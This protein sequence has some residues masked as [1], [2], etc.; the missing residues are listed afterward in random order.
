MKLRKRY[1]YYG[2]T[3]TAQN[4]AGDL[5][6]NHM[7]PKG[8]LKVPFQSLFSLYHWFPFLRVILQTEILLSNYLLDYM[9]QAIIICLVENLLLN[10]FCPD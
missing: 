10:D 2:Y 9:F 3:K 1:G 8:T 6:N 5:S 7:V 4:L